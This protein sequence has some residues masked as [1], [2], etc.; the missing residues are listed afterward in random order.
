MPDK[1]AK[2]LIA[3]FTNLKRKASRCPA[4]PDLTES[5]FMEMA[6]EVEKLETA[7][8]ASVSSTGGFFKSD[9]EQALEDCIK[10]ASAKAYAL[11]L[12]IEQSGASP[13]L[14]ECSI[15]A[16]NLHDLL[17]THHEGTNR[18]LKLGEMEGNVRMDSSGGQRIEVRLRAASG[19]LILVNPIKAA[20]GNVVRIVI[21]GLWDDP[22]N[23]IQEGEQP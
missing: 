23:Q 2:R 14:T 18:V 5:T 13:E 6:A 4:N 11:C 16:N 21:F 19:D 20:D 7:M 22:R 15:M 3:W 10:D 1:L 8:A 12:Q 9:R 17:Q